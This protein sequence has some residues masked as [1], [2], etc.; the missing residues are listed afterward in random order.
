MPGWK[1]NL[2]ADAEGRVIPS[3]V[4]TGVTEKLPAKFVGSGG[5]TVRSRSLGAAAQIMHEPYRPEG[6]LPK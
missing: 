3:C 4:T 1:A 5:P 6:G 2:P